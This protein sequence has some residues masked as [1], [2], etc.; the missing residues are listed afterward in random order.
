M[1]DYVQLLVYKHNKHFVSVILVYSIPTTNPTRL[2]IRLLR[3]NIHLL[4]LHRR[5]NILRHLLIKQRNSIPVQMRLTIVL[6]RPR[7]VKAEG[8]GTSLPEVPAVRDIFCV[9]RVGVFA[10]MRR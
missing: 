7:G 10:L 9:D 6:G 4:I 8:R 1:Y 2:T 5:R 3:N